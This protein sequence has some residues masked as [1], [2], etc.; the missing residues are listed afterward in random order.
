MNLALS[1][2]QALLMEKR[3]TKDIL[4]LSSIVISSMLWSIKCKHL[5][6]ALKQSFVDTST[7]KEK[8]SWK[9]SANGKK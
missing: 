7:S 1:R 4:I 2:K 6:K 5:L 9:K 8:K 3:K